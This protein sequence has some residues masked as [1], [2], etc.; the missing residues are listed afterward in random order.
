MIDEMFLRVAK[1]LTFAGGQPLT[2][3]TGF[4]H[5]HDDFL[6]LFR[7]L[8]VSRWLRSHTAFKVSKLLPTA[9]E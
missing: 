7:L 2:N 9:N 6:Y 1:V 8:M 5:Q 3:A 4:F